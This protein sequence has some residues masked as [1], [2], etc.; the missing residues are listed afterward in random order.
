MTEFDLGY[1]QIISFTVLGI[2]I[3]RLILLQLFG[4]EIKSKLEKD[5]MTLKS[6]TLRK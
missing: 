3:E 4:R 5:L 1:S 2:I 6:L